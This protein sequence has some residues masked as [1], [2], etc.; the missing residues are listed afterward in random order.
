MITMENT[1]ENIRIV[2]NSI[3]FLDSK[4][5]WDRS[6]KRIT[7]CT[8]VAYRSENTGSDDDDKRLHDER[9]MSHMLFRDKSNADSPRHTST[10]EHAVF[11]VI[12]HCSRAIANEFV[13][14]RHTAYTQESTRYVNFNK[15]S[16]EFIRP[17]GM[18]EDSL[19]A[20]KDS[21]SKSYSTYK[22]MLSDGILPQVARDV[23]P[24][25]LST[26]MAMTTNIAEWRCIFNLRCDKHAHPE[27][28][29]IAWT[30]LT[31]F[32]KN[33]PWAFSDLYD[34]FKGDNIPLCNYTEECE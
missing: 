18:N 10:V 16:A 32:N 12:L 25:G 33:A 24:L 2:E 21:C 19:E 15:K 31:V 29:S 3:E 6:L 23:L 8:R 7:R 26:T 1:N 22:D 34:K 4:N 14:H 11:G 13:R 17:Y 20:Y 27:A 5:D 28:R 9:L 30:I